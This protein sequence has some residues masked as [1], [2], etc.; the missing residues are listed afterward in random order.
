M[1]ATTSETI[2]DSVSVRPIGRRFRATVHDPRIG[3][4]MLRHGD[5]PEMAITTLAR[6]V[7]ERLAKLGDGT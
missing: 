4:R 7:D 3:G 2:I 5:T 6:A 1:T